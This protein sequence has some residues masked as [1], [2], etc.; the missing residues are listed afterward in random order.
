[1]KFNKRL[2]LLIAVAIIVIISNILERKDTTPPPS[3][4]LRQS[5]YS[6]LIT[7]IQSHA[8]KAWV[9]GEGE[10]VALLPDDNHGSRH[11][12]I[13]IKVKGSSNT[14]LIAHNIDLA[15]RVHQLR[16]GDTIGF[17]GEYIWNDKGGVLHWTHHDPKRHKA[18][19]WLEFRGRKYL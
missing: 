4:V 17:A 8:D 13:L 10:V 11:Q 16:K 7:A 2:L 5:G 6:S 19:G 3:S 9:K 14:V 18:G 15:P 1:M 12:R